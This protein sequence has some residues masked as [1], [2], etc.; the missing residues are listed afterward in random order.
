MLSVTLSIDYNQLCTHHISLFDAVAAPQHAGP[1]ALPVSP[2]WF[3]SIILKGFVI[4]VIAVGPAH[5]T[6]SFKYVTAPHG[7]RSS[8]MLCCFIKV[9]DNLSALVCL[10]T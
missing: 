8:S 10:F 2:F 1:V 6:A 7:S 5:K 9:S 3:F 4:T